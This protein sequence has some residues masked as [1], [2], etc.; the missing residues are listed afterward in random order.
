MSVT[1]QINGT[2]VP[3]LPDAG[4]LQVTA[5]DVASTQTSEAGTTLRQVTRKRVHKITATWTMPAAQTQTLA[6]LTA[7]SPMTLNLWLPDTGETTLSVFVGAF[8]PVLEAA[9]HGPDASDALWKTTL[10]FTEY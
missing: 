7:S 3:K 6:A 10:E 4:S 9:P 1:F 2:Q 5:E 8:N